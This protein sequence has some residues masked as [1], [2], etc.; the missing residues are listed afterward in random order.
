MITKGNSIAGAVFSDCEKYRYRLWRIWDKN[1][2][3]ACF[4][5]LNP[6]VADENQLDPTVTRCKKRAE[7]LGYG[8]MEIVNIFAL[9]STDP[10]ALYGDVDP[11]G[12]HNFQAIAA[13]VKESAIAI[14]GWGS[15][16]KYMNVGPF[17]RDRLQQ[18]YPAKFHCLK[19][20]ADGSPTHPLY[21]A[22]ELQPVLWSEYGQKPETAERYRA[23]PATGET[24]LAPGQARVHPERRPGRRDRRG[25]LPIHGAR[26][27]EKSANQT[28]SIEK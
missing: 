22:Y 25:K 23:N 28:R 17:I 1:K 8:G 16:G 24:A 4:V 19:I 9:R 2:P 20:N 21:L 11:V 18:F 14:C 3:K 5:M 10:K 27:D 6:S 26:S 13:A 7:T 15:H 12:L